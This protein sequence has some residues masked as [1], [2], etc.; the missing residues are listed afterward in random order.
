VCVCVCVCVCLCVWRLGIKQHTHTH[1]NREIQPETHTGEVL[2]A[3]G[4][5]IAEVEHDP[6]VALVGPVQI[7]HTQQPSK[8][9]FWNVA[10]AAGTDVADKRRE[11]V[12]LGR[13][14]ENLW[15]G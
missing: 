10:A 12:D 14:V 13:E 15:E 2:A 6:A 1:T 5:R 8:H 3:V 7:S 9:V 4:R 11:F